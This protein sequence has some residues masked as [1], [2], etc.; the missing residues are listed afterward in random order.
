MSILWDISPYKSKYSFLRNARAF[1]G[2]KDFF[3][4]LSPLLRASRMSCSSFS[5]ATVGTLATGLRSKRTGTGRVD[6]VAAEVYNGNMYVVVFCTAEC[7]YSVIFYWN[8]CFK[9]CF[10]LFSGSFLWRQLMIANYRVKKFVRKSQQS[11]QTILIG[12]YLL[13]IILK[14]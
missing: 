2:S 13:L 4:C 9:F 10:W 5:E 1:L 14:K 12:S 3:F 11:K 8:W 7:L 6:A